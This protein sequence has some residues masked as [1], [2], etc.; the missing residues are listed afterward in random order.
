MIG[1]ISEN[2]RNY[3]LSAARYKR[4]RSTVE[5]YM[6]YM[7]VASHIHV[8]VHVLVKEENLK[9]NWESNPGLSNSRQFLLLLSY[10][11][12]AC[13]TTIRYWS[14]ELVHTHIH[15]C[16]LAVRNNQL[17]TFVANGDKQRRLEVWLAV[18]CDHRRE[19]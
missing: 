14:R 6:M 9:S 13:T 10:M 15:V 8:H 2:D 5:M 1:K 17:D 7:H 3:K 19:A 12:N 4:S 11:Y 18:S 16:E